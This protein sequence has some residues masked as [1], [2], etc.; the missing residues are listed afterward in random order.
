MLDTSIHIVKMTYI[1]DDSVQLS[2]IYV[3]LYSI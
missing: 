2:D 1:S 3:R